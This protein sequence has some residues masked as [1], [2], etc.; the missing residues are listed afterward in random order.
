MTEKNGNYII[1][2]M[3]NQIEQ[4][5]NG[6]DRLSNY[7]KD[8]IGAIKLKLSDVMNDVETLKSRPCPRN[9]VAIKEIIEVEKLKS[10]AKR[11]EKTRNILLWIVSI[12]GGSLA[13]YFGLKDIFK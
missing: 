7:S 2:V 5:N 9:P 11:P 10:D 6:L 1:D 4:L 3:I 13:I 8:E 12:V